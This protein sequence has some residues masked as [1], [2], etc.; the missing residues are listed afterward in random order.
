VNSFKEV[1]SF[2]A[3]SGLIFYDAIVRVCFLLFKVS[4]VLLSKFNMSLIKLSCCN[5]K[6]IRL[7][8]KLSPELCYWSSK[9]LKTALYIR[10][11]G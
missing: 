5:T 11:L 3:S 2:L 10:G 1:I 9:S 6:P 8:L 7:F 4:F